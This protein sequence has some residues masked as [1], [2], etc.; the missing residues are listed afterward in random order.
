MRHHISSTSKSRLRCCRADH[1]KHIDLIE[2]L[3]SFNF[4]VHTTSVDYTFHMIC[5]LC[6]P[7]GH[8]SIATGHHT[9]SPACSY[10]L[11]FSDVIIATFESWPATAAIVKSGVITQCIKLVVASLCID[12]KCI[13]G[14]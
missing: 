9:N 12:R 5:K 2:F 3:R 13:L 10:G 1:H 6:A 4:I 7:N 8:R 11:L 14:I